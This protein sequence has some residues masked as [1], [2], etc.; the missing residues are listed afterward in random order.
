M[1]HKEVYIVYK[2]V[3]THEYPMC[4][5]CMLVEFMYESSGPINFAC[6][7]LTQYRAFTEFAS[8]LPASLNSP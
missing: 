3:A 6:R 8:E 1:L 5:A 7:S 2:E 4:I